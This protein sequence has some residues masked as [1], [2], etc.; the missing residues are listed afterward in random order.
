MWVKP[1]KLVWFYQEECD[2]V[3]KTK[4]FLSTEKDI[5]SLFLRKMPEEDFIEQVGID[6]KAGYTAIQS[7]TVGQEQ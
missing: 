3:I 5:K 1:T 6:N 2:A 4:K 7:R